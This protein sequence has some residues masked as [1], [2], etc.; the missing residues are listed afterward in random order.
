VL[1]TVNGSPIHW[2]SSR[3]TAVTHSSTEAVNI[4]ADAGAF[5]LVWLAQLAD[6]LR[7]PLVKRSTTLTIDDKPAATYH[8]G[9]VITDKRPES[10]STLTTRAQSIWRTLMDRQRGPST[11]MCVIT[12]YNN[13]SPQGPANQAVYYG[14]STC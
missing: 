3:Q 4:A 7:V 6:D 9:V 5:V 2:L 12:T 8:N 14:R 10:P 13:A 11:Y 1:V